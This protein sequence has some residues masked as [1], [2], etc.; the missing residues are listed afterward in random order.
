MLLHKATIRLG[1]IEVQAMFPEHLY[2]DQK[3]NMTKV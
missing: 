3:V 1:K 2:A